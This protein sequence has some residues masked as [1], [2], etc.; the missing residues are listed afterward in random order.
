MVTVSIPPPLDSPRG[1]MTGWTRASW[2][3]PRARGEGQR[4]QPPGP[5]PILFAS[6]FLSN[7]F[8]G[9]PQPPTPDLSWQVWVPLFLPS[10]GWNRTERWG[11]SEPYAWGGEWASSGCGTFLGPGG[12]VHRVYPRLALLQPHPQTGPLQSSLSEVVT[13]GR[14]ATGTRS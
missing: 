1:Q 10:E 11:F 2:R 13:G 12:G 5:S 14:G 6:K 9:F 8:W 7:T 4:C 3:L